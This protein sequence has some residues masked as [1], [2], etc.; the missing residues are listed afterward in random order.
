MVFAPSSITNVAK[1]NFAQ[2]ISN[3]HLPGIHVT[4]ITTSIMLMLLVVG[5]RLSLWTHWSPPCSPFWLFHASALLACLHFTIYP[6][7]RKN[8]LHLFAFCSSKYVMLKS[9]WEI[10]EVAEEAIERVRTELKSQFMVW[11]FRMCIC[12]IITKGRAKEWESN[13]A[14]DDDDE[15]LRLSKQTFAAMPLVMCT[16]RFGSSLK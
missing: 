4:G 13:D 9:E 6:Y 1:Y 11:K 15:K 10:V 12:I 8:S 5:I 3:W 16:N 7:G 14:D 2:F